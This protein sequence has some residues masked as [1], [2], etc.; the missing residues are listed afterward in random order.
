M[1]V[2]TYAIPCFK[3]PYRWVNIGEKEKNVDIEFR[4]ERLE[5]EIILKLLVGNNQ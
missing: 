3:Y 4:V 2:W 5:S 1:S